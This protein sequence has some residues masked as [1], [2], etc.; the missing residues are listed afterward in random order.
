MRHEF[1]AQW[2]KILL[3]AAVMDT[4]FFFLLKAFQ[5]GNVPQVV[6]LS[7]SSTLLT[8]L[9]GVVVLKENKH[10][11]LKIIAAGLATLGLVLLQL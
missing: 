6:A 9:A 11:A 1:H 2:K 8:A 7:A 3:N 4:S 10:I 5:L